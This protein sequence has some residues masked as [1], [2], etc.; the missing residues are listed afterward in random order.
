MRPPKNETLSIRTSAEVKLLLRLAAESE[1]R[2]I[3]S[4]IEVLI[5]AHADKR[6]TQTP[7]PTEGADPSVSPG[8][9]T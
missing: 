6:G 4:M 8:S 3:S 5:R 2:S 7:V 1:H 9:A